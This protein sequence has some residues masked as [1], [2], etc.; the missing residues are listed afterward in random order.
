MLPALEHTCNK[1]SLCYVAGNAGG[2]VWPPCTV[3]T[4]HHEGTI[5]HITPCI[6]S[7]MQLLT[8]TYSHSD[9]WLIMQVAG[10]RDPANRNLHS[11]LAQF[12]TSRPALLPSSRH[13]VRFASALYLQS[14]AFAMHLTPQTA[15]IVCICALPASTCICYSL[16]TIDCKK[17]LHLC[18][19]CNPLHLQV[20]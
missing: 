13:V 18:S 5:A 12:G 2:R 17:C 3:G 20:A 6:S 9:M 14:P 11:L 4:E 19:A 1:H 16:D 15:S 8:D 7:I 10:F